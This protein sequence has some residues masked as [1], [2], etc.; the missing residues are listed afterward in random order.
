MD[1]AYEFK[2][3]LEFAHQ[4]LKNEKTKEDKILILDF[5]LDVIRED[6]KSQKLEDNSLDFRIGVIYEISKMKHH[7][8]QELT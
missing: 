8:E 6:L 1:Q 5:M 3:V 2:Y 4:V 7:I